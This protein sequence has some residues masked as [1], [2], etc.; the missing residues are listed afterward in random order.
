MLFFGN[1]LHDFAV[2]ITHTD[3]A[4]TTD[5]LNRVLHAVGQDAVSGMEIIAGQTHFIAHDTGV[6][7]NGDLA[8]TRGLCSVAHNP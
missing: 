5:I 6:H 3:T 1:Y 2:I 8:C 7:R 4:E